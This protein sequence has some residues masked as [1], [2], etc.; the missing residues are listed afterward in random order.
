MLAAHF[1][2]TYGEKV[3]HNHGIIP[4]M[5]IGFQFEQPNVCFE[6]ECVAKTLIE[7]ILEP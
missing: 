6:G 2:R 7:T 3:E 4:V 1:P 5:R